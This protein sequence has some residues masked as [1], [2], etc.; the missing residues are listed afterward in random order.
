MNEAVS[1]SLNIN[2]K[3]DLGIGLPNIN[4][5]SITLSNSISL[6]RSKQDPHIDHPNEVSAAS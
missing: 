3:E 2:I 4:I 6:P 1:N 5:T